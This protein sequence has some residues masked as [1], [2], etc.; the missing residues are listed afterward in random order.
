MKTPREILTTTASDDPGCEGCIYREAPKT[1]WCYF[2][3]SKPR[4]KMPCWRIRKE[5]DRNA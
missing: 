4:D 1:A 5:G 3:R 2:W